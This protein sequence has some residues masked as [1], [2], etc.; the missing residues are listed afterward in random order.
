[1]VRRINAIH[2]ADIVAD[3]VLLIEDRVVGAQE[4][5]ALTEEAVV[6]HLECRGR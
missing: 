1:M 3:E 6:V 5:V 2:L 4:V